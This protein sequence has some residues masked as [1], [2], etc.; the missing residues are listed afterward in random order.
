MRERAE[1]IGSTL[2]VWSA[3]GQGTEIELTI[4]GRVAYKDP[5]PGPLSKLIETLTGRFGN[6]RTK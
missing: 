5:E 3:K 2:K 4:P 1:N 6:R